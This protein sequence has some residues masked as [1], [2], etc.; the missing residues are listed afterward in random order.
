MRKGLGGGLRQA[1]VLAAA[2]MHSLDTVMPRLH[3]DHEHAK[4]ITDG[5]DEVL[6]ESKKMQTNQFLEDLLIRNKKFR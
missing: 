5:N 1:G 3:E 6:E 2:A 4:M